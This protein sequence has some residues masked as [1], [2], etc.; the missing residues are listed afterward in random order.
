DGVD[1]HAYTF[2]WR[3]DHSDADLVPTDGGE[4]EV[5]GLATASHPAARVWQFHSRSQCMSC[6]SSWSEYAL[7]FQPEQLNRPGPDGRNQLVVFSELG[8]IRRAGKDG[9][10]LPP[11]DDASAARE[12]KL[13]DPADAGQPLEARARAYLHANCG[14]CHSNGGGGAVDLR[15]QFPVAVAQMKAVGIA[16]T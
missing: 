8:H 16:P 9:K 4:K 5:R 7:A 2:A 13:A 6:H 10:P 14:H 3:D 12:R 1:W 11:F 15:L